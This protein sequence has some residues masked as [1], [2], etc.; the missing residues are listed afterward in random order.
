MYKN[1]DF[2]NQIKSPLIR[3]PNQQVRNYLTMMCK[4]TLDHYRE[5]PVKCT[6]WMDFEVPLIMQEFLGEKISIE[7][8]EK[9]DLSIKIRK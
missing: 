1:L 9:M 3:H 7:I 6:R 4:I 2:L 5:W 8:D